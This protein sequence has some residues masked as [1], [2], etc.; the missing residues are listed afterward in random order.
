[1]HDG[2]DIRSSKINDS[3]ANLSSS[4]KKISSE[5]GFLIFKAYLALTQLK[6]AFTKALILYYFDL[7]Y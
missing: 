1:M 6:K 4:T 3:I 7:K 2:S 5:V